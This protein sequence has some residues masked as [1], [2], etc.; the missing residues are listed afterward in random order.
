MRRDIVGAPSQKL[1]SVRLAQFK[2]TLKVLRYFFMSGLRTLPA[3]ENGYRG[4]EQFE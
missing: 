3:C 1:L 2:N 4:G